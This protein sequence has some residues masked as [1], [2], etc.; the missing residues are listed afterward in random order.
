M[1][2]IK[3]NT[4]RIITLLALALLAACGEGYL[5]ELDASY[6][7]VVDTNDATAT[8]A[9]SPVVDAGSDADVTVDASGPD[10]ETPDAE[11]PDS[12]TPDSGE[13]ETYLELVEIRSAIPRAGC[14]DSIVVFLADRSTAHSTPTHEGTECVSRF[15]IPEEDLHEDLVAWIVRGES[16]GRVH[17]N[18]DGEC[19]SDHCPGGIYAVFREVT[20]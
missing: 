1:L 14:G 19:I 3:E 10:V 18:L 12:S 4:M 15:G 6:E 2:Y 11:I 8:D 13:P 5:P 9:S 17:F 16:W 7:D 20:R